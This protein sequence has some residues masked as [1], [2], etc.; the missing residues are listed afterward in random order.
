[1]LIYYLSIIDSNLWG[2]FYIYVSTARSVSAWARSRPFSSSPIVLICCFTSTTPKTAKTSRSIQT[3]RGVRSTSI[4]HWFAALYS[5]ST[6]TPA[7]E[8]Y[9]SKI[10]FGITPFLLALLLSLLHQ[11]FLVIRICDLEFTEFPWHLSSP[12]NT[13]DIVE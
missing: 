2:I 13:I 4:N 12:W 10:Y 1:M 8:N 6:G 9:V 11:I 5:A 7:M 3:P